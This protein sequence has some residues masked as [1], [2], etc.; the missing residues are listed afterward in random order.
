MQK[1]YLILTSVFLLS[2]CQIV[3]QYPDHLVYDIDL[4]NKVCGE[5]VIVNK[6]ALTF[7]WVRDLPLS[8][9][10]GNFALKPKDLSRIKNWSKDARKAIETKCKL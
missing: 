7:R 10:N 8:S 3:P 6:D 2:A 9:C 4:D 1:T 5:Y